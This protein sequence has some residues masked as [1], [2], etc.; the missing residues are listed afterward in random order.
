[1]SESARSPLFTSR[2]TE[3]ARESVFTTA[4]S[5]AV[6]SMTSQ[7]RPHGARTRAGRRWTIS[8]NRRPTLSAG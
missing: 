7:Q 8:F 4:R 5:A 1:M 3:R 2:A 6:Y